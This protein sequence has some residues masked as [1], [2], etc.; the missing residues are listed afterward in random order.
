MRRTLLA[1]ALLGIFV[2]PARAVSLVMEMQATGTPLGPP[3]AEVPPM[4]SLLTISATDEWIRIDRAG[5]GE[6]ERTVLV[7]VATGDMTTLD[8][9]RR[10]Y[11]VARSADLPREITLRMLERT[12]GPVPDQ[13]PVLKPTGRSDV[14]GDWKAE[15]F[16]VETPRMRITQW[17]APSLVKFVPVFA[18]ILSS[19]RGSNG[20]SNRPVDARSGSASGRCC[21]DDDPPALPRRRNGDGV[22]DSLRS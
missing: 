22:E 12:Y 16:V 18:E 4:V 10:I 19:I 6:G 8:H 2:G 5:S 9:D 13:R 14:V 11:S 1:V 3:R 7:E 21:E 20:T 15:E 17:V